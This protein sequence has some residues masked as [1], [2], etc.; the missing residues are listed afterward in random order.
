MPTIPSL[1][2]IKPSD[3]PTPPDA[4]IQIM[5]ACSREDVKQQKLTELAG[6]DPVVTAELL[7]VVNSPL[8]GLSREIK[9]I[10]RAVTI[11]GHR[12]LRNLALCIAV[13][14]AL[15][16][17]CISDFDAASY[18]EDTLRRAVAARLLGQHASV[19][20]DESFTAGLLL[21]FGLLVLFYKQ[22]DQ[23]RHWNE[24]RRLDPDKRRIKEQ[25]MFGTTH[26]QVGELL[27][28]A[29]Q[30]PEKFISAL[31]AHHRMSQLADDAESARLARV[32]YCA[33]WITFVFSADAP[34]GAIVNQLKGSRES[35]H[36]DIT[37]LLLQPSVN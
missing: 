10:A 26:D 13:R 36:D 7:R 16:P 2:A 30:L 24:I 31:S 33:D 23:A 11:I 25:A 34:Q 4:V 28:R 29:W 19:E 12:A 27:S 1:E 15:R 32:L 6:Y 37:L 9:S 18:W 8:Y 17:D 14:D 22:P 5:R 3:L 21:D 35:L 20:V